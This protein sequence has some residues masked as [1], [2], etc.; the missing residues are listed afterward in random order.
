MATPSN[1]PLSEQSDLRGFG[2]LLRRQMSVILLCGLVTA[3][4]TLAISL[5][6]A[7]QYRAAARILYTDPGSTAGDIGGGDPLR[8]VDTFTRLATTEAIL[9]PVAT[10]LRLGSTDKV[11]ASVSVTASANANLLEV[12][13]VSGTARGSAALANAVVSSLIEWRTANRNAQ[14]EARIAFLNEQ[15]DAFAGKT[16]P[17]EVAAASSVRAQL[18]ESTAQLRAPSPELT[19]VSRAVPPETAFSPKP[20]RNAI[21]GLI[22]GLL[23]GFLI[24]AL[25]DRLDR[26]LHSTE[27]IEQVYPWPLLGV[28][29]AVGGSQDPD[30]QLADFAGMS[31]LADAYRNIRTN[32]SLLSRNGGNQKVWV[33]SSAMPSEGK[34]AATANLAG[35]LAATGM[36]VLAIS[37]DLHSP[38]LHR[39]FGA[40]GRRRFGL[41]EVLAG[42]VRA[43][44][45][46]IRVP[47]LSGKRGN[48]G[49]VDVIANDR[50]FPDPA[51]LFESPPM[52]DLLASTRESY[53]AIV[54]DAP[55]LLYTAEASL[56]ARLADSLILV[57]RL[58]LLTRNQA[59]RARRVLETMH[60]APMGV[61]ATGKKAEGGYGAGYEYR[62]QPREDAPGTRPPAAAAAAAT[63]RA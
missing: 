47:G 52:A 55:P 9:S 14:L 38:G 20:V 16:S 7:K 42:N 21:V 26:K 24:G 53:D 23:L 22:A 63:R 31:H 51:I 62:Q 15:L 44:E 54:I 60:L 28:V 5:T 59:D 18:V 50:V 43:D 25:R 58:E 49:R 4:A 6:Q 48:G 3:G 46:A 1:Q 33:I 32:V 45:A 35:A 57:A 2:S 11:R 56:L 8:A 27:D 61:I 40:L 17:S 34:S 41:V 30:A 19:L 13:A 12:A 39:Y 10:S 36:R 29:P 37:A